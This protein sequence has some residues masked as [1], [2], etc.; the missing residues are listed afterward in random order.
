MLS[1]CRGE[2]AGEERSREPPAQNPGIRETPRAHG[3]RRGPGSREA[4]DGA[5]GVPRP[6]GTAPA[7][8]PR[9]ARGSLARGGSRRA[10]AGG[11]RLA[12]SP[13]PRRKARA[14]GELA[15][16]HPPRAHPVQQRER[17]LELVPEAAH[18][19]HRLGERG[20]R[21]ALGQAHPALELRGIRL[22]ELGRQV[23]PARALVGGVDPD[24]TVEAP[25]TRD[26][27]AVELLGVVGGGEIEHV[28]D[29]VL[30]VEEREELILAV[31]GDD[32]VDVLED[33]GDR[34]L[35]L[36]AA[37]DDEAARHDRGGAAQDDDAVTPDDVA[38]RLA[39]ERA[40]ARA[41]CAVEEIAAPVKEA[42][43]REGRCERPEALDLAQQLVRRAPGEPDERVGLEVAT[44][45]DDVALVVALERVHA[46]G[47]RRARVASGGI[48]LPPAETDPAAAN[49][50]RLAL[51][52]R[53][54]AT[55][56]AAGGG[57]GAEVLERHGGIAVPPAS[58]RMS[59][60]AERSRPAYHRPVA[61]V[62][63]SDRTVV[64][65]AHPHV[66]PGAARRLWPR[67]CCT[68]RARS[69]R[70]HGLD[71]PARHE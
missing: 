15:A 24:D 36:D 14:R 69:R 32:R 43:L 48:V 3:A 63:P 13:P 51:H 45:E 54:Q 55:P 68:A 31:L 28:I 53:G 8:R 61:D 70:R 35:G 25:G 6:A 12:A 4:R 37:E 66:D 19:D 50:G 56:A 34:P 38:D 29:L 49:A 44:L 27:T 7:R 52:P 57:N 16:R 58:T 41:V 22:A 26:E 33:A 40:L 30:A 62:Q 5:R 2:P 1:A 60:G 18:A 39:D 65:R 9:P 23:A 11:G 64:E 67:T 47:E 42:A 59:R 17:L 71:L 21:E 10:L 46:G 20:E